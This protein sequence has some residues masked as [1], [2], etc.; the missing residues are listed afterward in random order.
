[1]QN[2][3]RGAGR[4]ESPGRLFQTWRA[5]FELLIEVHADTNTE[6]QF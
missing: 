1:M 4:G 3:A 5:P 2:W 6:R